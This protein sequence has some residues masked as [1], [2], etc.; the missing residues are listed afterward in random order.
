[1]SVIVEPCKASPELLAQLASLISHQKSTTR[2]LQGTGEYY[3]IDYVQ[4]SESAWILFAH[5]EQQEDE[6]YVIKILCHYSDKRYHLDLLSRRQHCQ[7]EALTCNSIFSPDV[8]VGLANAYHLQIQ[9]KRIITSHPTHQL[10]TLDPY[11]EYALIMRRLPSEDRLDFLLENSNEKGLQQYIYHLVRRIVDIHNESPALSAEESEKW[12]SFPKLKQKLEHN[13]SLADPLFGD[14]RHSS[15]LHK[16]FLRLGNNLQQISELY[17]YAEFFAQRVKQG[18]IKHCHG[19]L[20]GPN[21][22][23]GRHAFTESYKVAILDAIDF[24]PMYSK[25]DTL[26]DFATLVI[27]IQTRLRCTDFARSLVQ[28]MIKQYLEATQQSGDKT[29]LIVLYYYLIEKAFV[30]ATISI[31]YD[32]MPQLGKFFLDVAEACWHDFFDWRLIA[33]DDTTHS[34]EIYAMAHLQRCAPGCIEV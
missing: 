6:Q 10:D 11:T 9:Q 28:Q 16:H 29:A 2:P 27:D 15:S 32:D 5:K 25:I 33:A 26:S 19:D 20:K 23:I 34:A 30:G 8:Y 7:K 31:V 4:K 3:I 18:H 17:P 22:W 14:D 1:M 21:I 13:I 24:N 12:G